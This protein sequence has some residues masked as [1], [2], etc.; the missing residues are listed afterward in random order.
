MSL[1]TEIHKHPLKH[2]I[3]VF[4]IYIYC[5]LFSTAVK[6]GLVDMWDISVRVLTDL[7]VDIM[8]AF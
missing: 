2:G 4:F 3:Q 7:H 5:L 6:P 1:Q 8:N